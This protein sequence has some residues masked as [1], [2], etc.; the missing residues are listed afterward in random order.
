M[1]TVL[2]SDAARLKTVI[3]KYGYS[4]D[5]AIEAIDSAI[6]LSDTGLNDFWVAMEMLYRLKNPSKMVFDTREHGWHYVSG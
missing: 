4:K 5:D 2:D 3:D 6:A 1:E